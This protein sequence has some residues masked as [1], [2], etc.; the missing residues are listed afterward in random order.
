MEENSISGTP[1]ATYR[2][3]IFEMDEPQL[4]DKLDE[5]CQAYIPDPESSLDGI[6]LSGM[7][8]FSLPENTSI[9]Q[10]QK[11]YYRSI[12]KVVVLHHKFADDDL[13]TGSEDNVR[14]LIK[15]NRLFEIFYYWEQSLRS[16]M[17]IRKASNPLYDSSLNTDIG[18]FRFRPIDPDTNTPYQNLILY[19]LSC[20]A[21]R[22]WRRQIDQCMERIYTKS[23]FDTHAWRAVMSIQEFV[24]S[25]TQKDVN[26]QQWHNATVSPGN[27]KSAIKY[28]EEVSDLHFIDIV[29]DRKLFSFRNGIYETA[30]WENEQWVDRWYPHINRDALLQDAG[31]SGDTPLGTRTSHDI[32]PKRSACNYFDRDFD[33]FADIENWYDIPTPHFQSILD[34]QEFS[35]EVCKWAYI[36]FCGRLLHE[37]GELDE[38]QVMPFLKG[39]AKSGKC[40]GKDTPIMMYDGS[41]KMVQDIQQGEK[42]MGDDSTPRTVLSTTQGKGK[43][44][45]VVQN[46][47]MNYIVNGEH[48]LSMVMTYTNKGQK[49]RYFLG[50][51][52]KK[53]DI[54]D[55]S[56]KDYLSLSIAQKK[57]LKGY[58]VSIEFPNRKTPIDPYFIGLWLGDGTSD[59]TH[60]T[61]QD[62]SIIKYLLEEAPKHDCF[63]RYSNVRYRYTILGTNGTNNIRNILKKLNLIGNKHIPD[64]Y[65][66]NST[67]NRLRL[68][69]GLIDSDGHYERGDKKCYDMIQK[70]FTLS[71]DI[72]YVVKSLG[73][74]TKISKC[75]KGCMYKNEYRKNTYYR[76]CISG[77]NLCDIPCLVPRKKALVRKRKTNILHTGIRIETLKE[78]DYYG[79]QLDGNQR[80]LMGDGTVTHNSTILT[81]VSK[82]FFDPIDVGTLSNNCEKKFGLSAL[83]DKLMFIAPE[84]KGNI[85]LEQCDF[86]TI[87]SG[88][89][90]SVPEKFKT[91]QSVKWSVPGAMAG[92]EPPEYSDNQGSISRR[93]VVFNFKKKVKKGD[94]QL[95]RKLLREIPALIVKGNRAYL[96]AVNA[97]GKRDIWDNVLPPY[98]AQTQKD[99]SEQTNS[100]VHFLGSDKVRFGKDQWI[101]QKVFIEYYNEHVRENSL[102][103]HTWKS[104]YY[105]GPLEERDIE[106]LKTSRLDPHEGRRYN[107][108]WFRGVD[109]KREDEDATA[110]ETDNPAG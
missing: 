21:E 91:A 82:Q 41:I 109:V 38:W 10:L 58:K 1:E 95:G 53:G 12:H 87:I 108:I 16:L 3:Q 27:T 15:F 61:T 49:N 90:T 63:T 100:L 35:E 30:V 19:L 17:N 50:K 7:K 59:T 105:E 64:V 99:M 25:R 96:E 14:N 51:P 62:S 29:K 42:V 101:R 81:K 97:F 43:L 94:T 60:I 54:V 68:L 89:D 5:L 84:I 85:G 28:L 32:C 31:T 66:F 93:I 56:V 4:V 65:K 78:G 107:C 57:A 23:G 92:N 71:K 75:E 67:E 11:E 20:L 52:Y 83:K 46:Q 110:T 73:F 104:D 103:R 102:R 48:M 22:G 76:M 9:D 36:L 39:K 37:V 33:H 80:L 69:A 8:I 47:G 13:L 34:Y 55:I 70:N 74:Y 24:Y 98:F 77:N 26:Y 86:Q 44:F 72:E 88:E 40:W 2:E 18:L 79:F 45:K 106:V 6:L